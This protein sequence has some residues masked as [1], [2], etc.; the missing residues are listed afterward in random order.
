MCLFYCL[1]ELI[2]SFV[3]I[4]I[5]VN[6]DVVWITLPS[7]TTHYNVF[8]SFYLSWKT[9]KPKNVSFS[10]N[11]T[12]ALRDLSK[13]STPPSTTTN[14]SNVFPKSWKFNW[15]HDEMLLPFVTG[16]AARG[17]VSAAPSTRLISQPLIGV[18]GELKPVPFSTS[19][20]CDSNTWNHLL[21]FSPGVRTFFCIKLSSI[22]F[23]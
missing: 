12:N 20:W 17:C 5:I 10:A 18:D 2:V 1:E 22:N 15:K 14:N 11:E 3:P 6:E 19:I 13:V 9:N 21:H 7:T 16:D 23:S 8:L 4:A